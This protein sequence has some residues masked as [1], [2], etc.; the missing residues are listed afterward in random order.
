M[1]TYERPN[2]RLSNYIGEEGR[3]R[4]SYLQINIIY[5]IKEFYSIIALDSMT[6]TIPFKHSHEKWLKDFDEYKTLFFEIF[7][8]I[9]YDYTVEA[10]FSELRHFDNSNFNISGLNS[11]IGRYESFFNS[12]NFTSDSILRLGAKMFDPNFNYWHSGYGG[13]SWYE[14]SK[15]GL[16][17]QKIPDIIFID[18]C[19]DLEH[20]G[21]S[22]FDKDG[23]LFTMNKSDLKTF[24]DLK[25]NTINPFV[26][27]IEA[28]SYR[29]CNLI[30]R[31]KNLDIFDELK[32]PNDFFERI[33]IRHPFYDPANH[34]E[35]YSNCFY[36]ERDKE[37]KGYNKWTL[38]S[39]YLLYHPITWGEKEADI[40]C[41]LY[42]NSQEYNESGYNELRDD[43]E[44]REENEK[45]RVC[46]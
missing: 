9:I 39:L 29:M 22:Y 16:M 37:A 8:H 13:K 42:R 40:E 35:K 41:K 10:V 14:I 43:R 12:H 33:R 5:L 15:A 32:L 44:R 4:Y 31:A 19:I 11:C 34:F 45:E 3:I 27:L 7:S 1:Y 25:R 6:R 26:I 46:K 38:D 36:Y 28:K 30:L 24:L 21:G 2:V 20:N 17:Y 23:F 18:H